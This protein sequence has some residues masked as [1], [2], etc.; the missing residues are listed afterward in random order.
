[1][2]S[3]Y[4]TLIL[5]LGVSLITGCFN[6]ANDPTVNSPAIYT[7][8]YNGNGANNGDVPVDNRKYRKDDIVT[9]KGNTGNLRKDGRSFVG[10]AT[11]QKATEA[12][13]EKD[14]TFRITGSLTLYAVW[15][16]KPYTIAFDKNDAGAGGS[17]ASLR[18]TRLG[19]PVTLPATTFTPPSGMRFRGWAETPTGSIIQ[20][21]YRGPSSYRATVTLYA[22][23]RGK[24]YSIIFDKND[25]GAGGSQV[26]LSGLIWRASVTL[27][28]AATT[29]LTPPPGERLLG[30]AETPN[31]SII[32]APYRGP[33]SYSA[34][35]TLYALWGDAA[36]T[37]SFDKN[38]GGAGGTQADKSA[39][40][41]TPV[42]LPSAT[43][44]TPPSGMRFLGW[45]TSPTGTAIRGAYNPSVYSATV[46]LYARW[47]NRSY[48]IT[49]DK[50]HRGAGGSQ[51]SLR[52]PRFGDPV[53]TLPTAATTTF[54]PPT[55]MRFLGWAETSD[56]AI[57]PTPYRGPSSYSAIV[58]LYARWISA[59]VTIPG[60]RK[61]KSVAMSPDGSKLAA[62]EYSGH[63]YTATISGSTVTW[64]DHSVAN[65]TIDGNK[66]WQ[67]V[68]ISSDG[69]KL[70]AVEY[71]GHLYT[72][73][74]SG[75]TVT[76][77]DRSGSGSAIAGN[78]KW[79]AIAMSSD[80]T[81]LA[82]VEYRGHLYTATI[83]GST[84]TWTDHS[85]ANP[86]IAGNKNW[87][88][89]AMS[90]D[91]SKLAAVVGDKSA[92]GGG[93]LYTATISGS[94][95]TWTDRSTAGS[96]I[97]GNKNWQAIAMSSNGSKLAAVVNIGHL[98]TA[99][100]SGSTVTWTDRSGSG[101]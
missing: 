52:V 42:T 94:A 47:V 95:V 100:I 59:R 53:K 38:H 65:P 49:F 83:S 88:A 86:T 8:T 29:T 44:F 91:G 71:R 3:S 27:P 2:K 23:W 48:T 58:T 41:G 54:T 68:A 19:E 56:G 78:K 40:F 90:S 70:A 64:T 25:T 9:V 35:V 7:L 30:W 96:V 22:Q 36:Y 16:S 50:N 46:T 84:V 87:Q 85:V 81:K 82:A 17:Q 67:S 6:P 15:S 72:A 31:G 75:S 55:G 99:S 20:A 51:D 77:T 12:Q 39:N 33:S 14:E 92:M 37:I 80:G 97:A 34:T 1:M 79:Q 21:P 89:I 101:S 60:D 4:S 45:A 61:W 32:Q 74:I 63:L 24:P 26:S 13:L 18:V 73:S 43:T 57:V 69:T 66:H 28:T 76:W 62:V 98:Y 11:E 10:W 93:H 5:A